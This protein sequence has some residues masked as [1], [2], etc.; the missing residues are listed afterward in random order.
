MDQVE[1]L[2][3]IRSLVREK[4]NRFG[5]SAEAVPNEAMLI[6]D[7]Y[8]CGRRF[9][10]DGLEAVWFI[11]ENQIKFFDRDGS[12]LEVLEVTGAVFDSAETQQRRAA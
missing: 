8:F 12:I 10:R 4:L 3:Q 9:Q 7:G 2:A 5:C 6:R 1:I 11:E